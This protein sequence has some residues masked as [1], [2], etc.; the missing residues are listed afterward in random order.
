MNYKKLGKSDI[1]V[2]EIA[3][4]CMSLAD[5]EQSSKQLLH[6]ALDNGINFFDTADI[7]SYGN[8]EITLGKAFAGKRDKIILA[9]KV[10]NQP[11]ADGLGLDW[12]PSK[13]HILE[14]IDKSLKRLQTDYIDLYQLHGGTLEDPIDETISAFEQLKKEGKIRSMVFPQSG[15]M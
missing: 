10:G 13:K 14:S 3:F 7:Y 11:R 5:D 4:G 12:N 6:Q 8:N 2:S 1:T 9:T 15:L